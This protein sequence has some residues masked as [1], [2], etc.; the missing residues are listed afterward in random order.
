MGRKGEKS[1]ATGKAFA[2]CLM[3][4]SSSPVVMYGFLVGGSDVFVAVFS[5]GVLQ[6]VYPCVRSLQLQ[7]V[8]CL[9]S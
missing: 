2:N 3:I 4:I 5:M 9:L 8:G 7:R 1:H 6:C